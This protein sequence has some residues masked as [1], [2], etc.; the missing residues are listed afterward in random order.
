M[1]FDWDS[2]KVVNNPDLKEIEALFKPISSLG[3]IV[4]PPDGGSDGGG[5]DDGGGEGGGGYVDCQ[6]PDD[7]YPDPCYAM[8]DL[9]EAQGDSNIGICFTTGTVFDSQIAE[10]VDDGSYARK[11]FDY[12]KT[13][14]ATNSPARAKYYGP[15]TA[16]LPLYLVNQELAPCDRNA[17]G[18]ETYA[19][20]CRGRNADDIMKFLPRGA[21]YSRENGTSDQ[22][23]SSVAQPP[24]EDRNAFEGVINSQT[25]IS[26][27]ITYD[28]SALTDNDYIEYKRPGL[29]AFWN[30]NAQGSAIQD[31]RLKSWRY[32]PTTGILIR[33]QGETTEQIETVE[34]FQQGW[35]NFKFNIVSEFEYTVSYRLNGSANQIFTLP[36]GESRSSSPTVVEAQSSRGYLDIGQNSEITN[37]ASA[38]VVLYGPE[39]SMF[40]LACGSELTADEKLAFTR[41]ITGYVDVDR[42]VWVRPEGCPDC[43]PPSSCQPNCGAHIDAVE[44]EVVEG[45]MAIIGKWHDNTGWTIPVVSNPD[46]DT[47]DFYANVTGIEP[48]VMPADRLKFSTNI[49]PSY[50][51]NN[52]KLATI[53]SVL[54]ANSGLEALPCKPSGATNFSACKG[55][56]NYISPQYDIGKFGFVTSAVFDRDNWAQHT[57]SSS[58]SYFF[59]VSVYIDFDANPNATL[60]RIRRN[61]FPTFYMKNQ[62]SVQ[63]LNMKSP[64]LDI[65]YDKTASIDLEDGQGYRPIDSSE[66]TGWYTVRASGTWKIESHPDSPNAPGQPSP[67]HQ[68]L[69]GAT[70]TTIIS[71]VGTFTVSDSTDSNAGTAWVDAAAYSGKPV[72]PCNSTLPGMGVYALGSSA[73]QLGLA[74]SADSPEVDFFNLSLQN[75]VLSDDCINFVPPEGCPQVICPPDDCPCY[76]Q[77]FTFEPLECASGEVTGGLYEISDTRPITDGS[78]LNYDGSQGRV[79]EWL[80]GEPS[81]LLPDVNGRAEVFYNGELHYGFM[82]KN[83]AQGRAFSS[84]LKNFEGQAWVGDIV[85]TFEFSA[86]MGHTGN[87]ATNNPELITVP[88][89]RSDSPGRNGEIQHRLNLYLLE[90]NNDTII[91]TAGF[92]AAVERSAP[93]SIR[94]RQTTNNGGDEYINVDLPPSI[95]HP[96]DKFFWVS[97]KTTFTL[98][99]LGPA[100]EEIPGFTGESY[101]TFRYSG[102][103]AIYINGFEVASNVPSNYKSS[104]FPDDNRHYENYNTGVIPATLPEGM[105]LGSNQTRFGNLSQDTIPSVLIYGPNQGTNELFVAFMDEGPGAANLPNTEFGKNLKRIDPN[106]GPDDCDC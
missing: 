33:L 17:V 79:K 49:D 86:L 47:A 1:S 35:F 15:R 92:N 100:T 68:V 25:D 83:K 87:Q 43:S 51:R 37:Q 16:S 78:F 64:V 105:R 46:D 26:V 6:P 39:G 56:N 14:P 55:S 106:Y 20:A 34:P 75:P 9:A 31:V 96:D 60:A 103:S 54:N 98:E 94:Y 76:C 5:T 57:G 90:A 99:A 18:L 21:Y 85:E 28:P 53:S 52:T 80:K 71:P 19:M 3:G 13:D 48:S 72:A 32:F 95:L 67:A 89:K 30:Q 22:R 10:F 24:F 12:S 81:N 82:D 61:W 38:E 93:G 41:H 77:G 42:P 62:P 97:M 29:P 23:Y 27:Y 102:R 40:V 74:P 44:G 2:I 36:N 70:T 63:T 4:S 91:S 58:G 84:G 7:F 73:I 69:T 66:V 59:E 65:S 101:Y 104:Y 50:E 11:L 8:A 45:D 88:D